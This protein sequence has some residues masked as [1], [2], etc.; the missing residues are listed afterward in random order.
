M[1]TSSLGLFHPLSEATAR[2]LHQ[3]GLWNSRWLRA[4]TRILG[5]LLLC[6]FW[7]NAT[8]FGLVLGLFTT[9][10]KDSTVL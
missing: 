6:D 9:E 5:C 3:G 10:E 8:Q 4:R 2:A 1:L 7:I